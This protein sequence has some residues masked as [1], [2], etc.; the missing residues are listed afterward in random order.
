[1]ARPELVEY[2]ET[3]TPFA[4]IVSFPLPDIG[5]IWIPGPG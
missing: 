4:E 5:E 3:T 2:P 1:V